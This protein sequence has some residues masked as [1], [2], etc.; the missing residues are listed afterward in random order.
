MPSPIHIYAGK[1]AQQFIAANGFKATDTRVVVGASG[2][3]K[4]FVLSHLDRYLIQHWLPEIPHQVNLIGSSIGAWRM[5]AYASKDPLQAL[6]NLEHHYLNQR[7]SSKPTLADIGQSVA[8]LVDSFIHLDDLDHHTTRKVHLVSARTKGLGQFEHKLVQSIACAGIAT[9]NML[10]RH[11]LPAWFDRVLFQSADSQLPIEHWD[12]FKT[13]TVALSKANYRDAILASGA[14]P[15]VIPG[16][17]NPDYAPK[18]M[19]R[20]GGMVDYHFDLPLKP[21][22]GFVLYPHFF[23]QLKPGWFDKKLPWRK[24]SADNYSH[25]IVVCPSPEFIATLPYHKIPDRKDFVRLDTHSRLRYWNTVV[26]RS[27]ALAD[28]YDQ[29]IHSNHQSLQ[30]RSIE[31]IAHH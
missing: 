11:S 12:H 13:T 18:G 19:Y 28:A 20:D 29:W 26:D 15:I 30:V 1:E 25:T 24:V 5:A 6:N 9:S 14:I 2:G 4:W 7:Y 27:K 31:E 8:A 22:N 16:I 3:P 21:Q 10:S 23:P 17:R